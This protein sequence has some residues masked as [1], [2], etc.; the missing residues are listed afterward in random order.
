MDYLKIKDGYYP[1]SSIKFKIIE[2]REE[3]VQKVEAI[4]IPESDITKQIIGTL[5]GSGTT[6]IKLAHFIQ[7]KKVA[8]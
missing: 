6:E 8:L 1:L 4:F 7:D 5:T 2:D 3:C